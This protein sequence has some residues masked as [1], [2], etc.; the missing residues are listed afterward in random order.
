MG[1]RLLKQGS[2]AA[3]ITMRVMVRKGRRLG[4]AGIRGCRCRHR[5]LLVVAAVGLVQLRRRGKVGLSAATV[6]C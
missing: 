5:S 1:M 3:T 4:M 6:V 2:G